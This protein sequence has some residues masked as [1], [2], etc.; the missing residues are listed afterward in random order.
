MGNDSGLGVHSVIQLIITE[1]LVLTKHYF[2]LWGES[3]EQ[4]QALIDL[5]FW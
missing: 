2:R 1:C 4:N 3:K 5:L